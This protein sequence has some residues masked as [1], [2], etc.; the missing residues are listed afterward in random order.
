MARHWIIDFMWLKYC[1]FSIFLILLRGGTISPR[2]AFEMYRRG[3][4]GGVYSEISYLP[5]TCLIRHDRCS[6]Q[7]QPTRGRRCWFYILPDM[8]Y[9]YKGMAMP[10]W[11]GMDK[12]SLGCHE[13]PRIQRRTIFIKIMFSGQEHTSEAE[14][15]PRSL[16]APVYLGPSS[17]ILATEWLH[18]RCTYWI[19]WGD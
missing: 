1:I 8:K 11:G 10:G 18:F 17:W 15:A 16:N 7:V 9:L 19:V 6:H 2:R 4:P 14:A 5:G 12:T 3:L 13:A